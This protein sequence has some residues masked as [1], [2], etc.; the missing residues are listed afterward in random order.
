[1]RHF[2]V[3]QLHDYLEQADSPP[4]LLDVREPWEFE[5]CHLE[6]SQLIPMGRIH[7]QL[8]SL[9]RE[10]ETVVICHH[11]VRSL[12]VCYFLANAGFDNLINLSGGIDAWA[13]EIDSDMATY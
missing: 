1:M 5:I 2:T 3:R 6:G 4:V 12:R 10:R 7:E 8:E 11:G 9:D 13:K